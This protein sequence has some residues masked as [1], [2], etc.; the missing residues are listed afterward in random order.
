MTFEVIL[1]TFKKILCL[2]NV[3]ILEKIERQTK[4]ISQKKKIFKF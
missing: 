1:T 4:K 3:D 2:N